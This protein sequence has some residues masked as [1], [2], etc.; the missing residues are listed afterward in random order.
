MPGMRMSEMTMSG[1]ILPTCSSAL[2]P[3]GAM[4]TS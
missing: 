1:R 4:T 2:V 3:S